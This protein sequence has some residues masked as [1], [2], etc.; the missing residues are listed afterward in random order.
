MKKVTSY[1]PYIHAYHNNF[2]DEKYLLKY[3]PDL[4][5]IY[6]DFQRKIYDCNILLLDHPGTTLITALI[7]NIPLICF[8]DKNHF[9][10]CRQAELLLED[11]YNLEIY[12]TDPL[13]AAQ[14]VNKI[15]NKA[16]EWWENDEIQ[17]ARMNYMNN[18]ALISK[19]W[20]KDWYKFLFSLQ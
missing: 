5:I 4:N 3:F 15:H 14:K 11:F 8:W 16:K 10:F 1:R 9:P 6:R 2:D 18:H 17:I 7:A 12:F 19:H 13:I 20:K